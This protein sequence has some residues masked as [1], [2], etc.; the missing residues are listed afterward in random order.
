MNIYIKELKTEYTPELLPFTFNQTGMMYDDSNYI[1]FWEDK[2]VCGKLGFHVENKIIFLQ[3]CLVDFYD[4]IIFKKIIK[5]IL[6][7]LKPKAIKCHYSLYNFFNNLYS[8]HNYSI[9]LPSSFDELLLRE[10]RKKRYNLKR[11]RRILFDMGISFRELSASEFEDAVKIFFAQKRITHNRDW[12]LEPSEFLK[13]LN[14]TNIYVLEKDNDFIAFALSDEHFKKVIFEQTAYDTRWKK[15]SPGSVI[16]LCF[17][18]KMIEKGYS[19]V[20]LGGGQHE[21]KKMLGSKEDFTFNGEI[22]R[23]YIFKGFYNFIRGIV[24]KVKHIFVKVEN[25]K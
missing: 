20:F 5:Y 18:G 21:Y 12:N 16:Y 25:K 15:Y 19:E 24:S 14:I 1:L 8:D 7:T 17:L 2:G 3:T 11:E 22:S 23:H 13:W 4:K 6:K 10:D 9:E